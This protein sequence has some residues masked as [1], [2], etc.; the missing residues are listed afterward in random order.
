MKKALINKF[1]NPVLTRLG[2]VA[3]NLFEDREHFDNFLDITDKDFLSFYRKCKKFS[4]NTT[5]KMY[6]SYKAIEY[7][8][9]N[10]IPGDIVECGVWRGGSC[11]LIALTLLKLKNTGKKIYLFD[12]YEGMTIPDDVDV[13][14][15]GRPARELMAEREARM[16][17]PLEEVKRNMFSTGYPEDKLIFI[18]GRVEDTVPKFLPEKISLL[19][20]DTDWFQSEYHG[21][22][23]AFPRLQPK[24]VIILDNY[25]CWNGA[26]YAADK[27]FNENNIKIL[28]NRT[29]FSERV[30][31]KT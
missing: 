30:G 21:L 24:G 26:R 19:R 10:D 20:I 11:M 31:I 7:I 3:V 9:Y 2:Y 18:K 1:V 4:F 16:I 29:N 17:A 28:L 27:Y 22:C 23:H 15:D 8:V 14:F 12:T 13:T 25:G 6:S 5:Q